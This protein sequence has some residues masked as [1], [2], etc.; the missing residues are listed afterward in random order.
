VTEAA[1]RKFDYACR[2]WRDFS[3]PL[4]SQVCWG[5][6]GGVS[7]DVRLLLH[8]SDAPIKLYLIPDSQP[9]RLALDE[10]IASYRD[11]SETRPL[12][13]GFRYLPVPTGFDADKEEARL[14]MAEE[15]KRR[16]CSDLLFGAVFG[17]LTASDVR[18]FAAHGGPFGLKFAML[19]HVTT[20]PT[21]AVDNIGRA[22]GTKS[23][24]SMREGLVMLTATGLL[25]QKPRAQPWFPTVKGRFLLDLIRRL[26][27]EAQNHADWSGELR[28]I[29]AHL[30]LANAGFI[31]LHEALNA[32]RSRDYARG[33][34]DVILELLASAI[35]ARSFG[36]DAL[37]AIDPKT[38]QLYSDFDWRRF[39]SIAPPDQP[40]TFTDVGASEDQGRGL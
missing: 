28:V 20:V 24:S 17:Q 38:P 23:K 39:A 35:T 34:L 30:G 32:L 22:L 4:V 40:L 21:I 5:N 11:R 8:D 2:L 36:V 1:R 3:Q 27:W 29:L 18:Y 25:H 9:A 26:L 19:H 13:R 12:L 10:A 33:S 37:A 16:M 14:W 15:L 31:S 7:K 6:V